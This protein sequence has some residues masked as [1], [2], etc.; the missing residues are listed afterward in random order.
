MGCGI[1]TL[2]VED[3]SMNQHSKAHRHAIVPPIIDKKKDSENGD[4]GSIGLLHGNN[5]NKDVIIIMR[6][7]DDEGVKDKGSNGER[8]K[9]KS[10]MERNKEEAMMFDIEGKEK[11]SGNKYYAKNVEEN[12]EDRDD[13]F[14]GPGSPSFREYCIDYDCEDRSSVVDSNDCDSMER[15]KN[16]NNLPQEQGEEMLEDHI[17][18]TSIMNF[19]TPGKEE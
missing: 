18:S 14:I 15:T 2:D 16:N 4:D 8:L 10:V 5:N 12:H 13:S 7:L 11:H 9:E 6:P 3:A 19:V 1:S 17:K